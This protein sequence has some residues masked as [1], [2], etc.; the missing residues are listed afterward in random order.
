MFTFI[1]EV[2][3]DDVLCNSPL[4]HSLLRV[5]LLHHQG[6]EQHRPADTA[7]MGY[8]DDSACFQQYQEN[9]ITGADKFIFSN[10]PNQY[11]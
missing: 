5:P 9:L 1:Q 3:D 4:L 8:Q 10:I 2:H 11:C 7:S 6:G